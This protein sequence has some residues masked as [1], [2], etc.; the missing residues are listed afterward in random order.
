MARGSYCGRWVHPSLCFLAECLVAGFCRFT[1]YDVESN[2]ALAEAVEKS[3]L[4]RRPRLLDG[5]GSLQICEQ[6]NGRDGPAVR[7]GVGSV[8]V[9]GT[10]AHR[11]FGGDACRGGLHV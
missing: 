6:C 4:P 11:P 8:S 7:V 2:E 10:W 5:D 1:Q 9:S 3:V